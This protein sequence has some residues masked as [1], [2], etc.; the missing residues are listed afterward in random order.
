MNGTVTIA[1]VVS[2]FTVA[3]VAVSVSIYLHAKFQSK[4]EASEQRKWIRK[5]ENDVSLTNTGLASIATDVSYIRGRL[6]E[7]KKIQG[8]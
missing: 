1:L 4:E 5:I 8:G 6:D 2:C 3:C 7:I